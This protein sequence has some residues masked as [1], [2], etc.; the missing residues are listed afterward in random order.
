MSTD[1][2]ARDAQ[3][4]PVPSAGGIWTPGRRPLTIGLVLA[5]TL[6]AFEAL[7]IATVLPVVSR[8]LGDLRLYGWVFS[9]FLLSS[10]IGIVVAGTLADRVPIGRPMLAGLA[11]F[12]VG[13]VIGGTAPTMAILVAGRA[14]QGL[15]AGVVPAVAYVAISRGYPE[16]C[17]PRMFAVLSTAW[18]IPGLI[19]PAIAALVASAVG[20]R[21]VFLGLLPLVAVAGLLATLALRGV[22]RPVA[23]ARPELPYLPVLG[24]V[25]GAGVALASLSSGQL[26]IVVAGVLAGGALLVVSLRRLTPPG[27][28]L[29]RRGLPATILS[30]GLLTCSFFAGDAYVPY[31]ITA[32]R[33][34]PTELGALALSAAT[35]TWTAGSWVQA[36]WI[37]RVGPRRLIRLGEGMVFI[38]LALMSVTLLPSVPV[39][40]GIVAWAIGGFG[41]GQA[42]S[43]LSVTTLDRATRGQEG[44]A[45]S[46]L[47]LFDVLGQA[48][49]TGVA[50][51]IV[52][53][54]AGGLGHRDGVALA[55][56][57]ALFVSVISVL[58]GVRLPS[59]LTG[60]ET[61]DG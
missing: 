56:G 53:G 2:A 7:A 4:P 20:W 19:G 26:L 31:A 29:A 3:M 5:V 50:G 30:R 6:V 25:A 39:A 46:S 35:M 14:V 51:A 48:V 28:L 55:F 27:T 12:A 40:L 52:A 60:P 42:Y 33:H 36:R 22:P 34:A 47:Q 57:F 58:V 21:W 54:A 9:A 8:Q 17:R 10:L 1:Q 45:T 23:T 18:V 38:G 61:K 15:G 59:R 32:V 24:V 16:G 11:L 43:P 13:L 44:R 41:I 49:G 37:T